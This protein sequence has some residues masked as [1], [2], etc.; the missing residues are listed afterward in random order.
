MEQSLK[1]AQKRLQIAEK[2]LKQTSEEF[3]E[4]KKKHEFREE[5]YTKLYKEQQELVRR[6]AVNKESVDSLTD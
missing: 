3:E 6:Q 4:L 5:E 1:E 2:N